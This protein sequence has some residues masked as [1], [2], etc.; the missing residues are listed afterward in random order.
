M[1]SKKAAMEMSVGTMVTIVLLMIVLVL[2]VVLIRSIFGGSQDAVEAINSQIT[3]Q[4]NNAFENEGARASIAPSSRRITL[5]RDKDPAGFAFSVRNINS[6]QKTF[7]YVVEA[8][9][10]SECGRLTET[11]ATSYIVGSGKDSFTLDSG[12]KLE[13]PVLVIFDIP[14]NA[15]PCTAIYALEVTE[16]TSVY[17]PKTDIYVTI[18]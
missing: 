8:K 15:P 10:T 5:E 1:E 9:D 14:E 7:S 17:V 2:G 6:E 12:S 13:Q 4:I 16:G 18:R 3:D 11:E